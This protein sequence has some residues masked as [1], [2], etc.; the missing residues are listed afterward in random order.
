[1][2]DAAPWVLRRGC[3]GNR[4][5]IPPPSPG[6]RDISICM[7]TSPA[8]RS[9]S[10]PAQAVLLLVFPHP[11]LH[12]LTPNLPRPRRHTP[13]NRQKKNER[14]RSLATMSRSRLATVAATMSRSLPA[15]HRSRAARFSLA[16]SSSCSRLPSAEGAIG[17]SCL[18]LGSDQDVCSGI[19]VYGLWFRVLNPKP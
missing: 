3:L 12:A 17:D 2:A 6:P 5:M 9:G 18:S 4:C 11:G 8:P 1:V 14:S 16:G 15:R 19:R 7:R 13:T 10:A